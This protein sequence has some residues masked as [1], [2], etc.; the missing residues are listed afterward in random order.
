VPGPHPA[1][2]PLIAAGCHLVYNE[3]FLASPGAPLPD[4]TRY[5]PSGVFL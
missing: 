5:L 3:T 2:A 1:L 4:V